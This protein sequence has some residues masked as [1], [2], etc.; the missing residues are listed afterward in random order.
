MKPSLLGQEH[1]EA[2]RTVNVARLGA[3][4]VRHVGFGF[5]EHT[6]ERVALAMHVHRAIEAT[7]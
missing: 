4:L 2:S 6:P 7:T 5:G 3:W 1:L